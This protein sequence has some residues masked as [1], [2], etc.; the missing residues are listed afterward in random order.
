MSEAARLRGRFLLAIGLVLA[1]ACSK[2]ASSGAAARPGLAGD[3][4]KSG[5]QAGLPPEPSCTVCETR[6]P[7]GTAPGPMPAPFERCATTLEGGEGRFTA[8]FTAQ[9]REK[10]N[11]PSACCYFFSGRHPAGPG[12]PYIVDGAARVA[13][14]RPRGDW[15]QP[16]WPQLPPGAEERRALAAKWTRAGLVEHASIAS[17]ARFAL[18]L[19]GHGAPADLV[20]DA[21]QA[22]MDEVKHARVSFALASAYGGEPVGPGP[23]A[24]LDAPPRAK[25]ADVAMATL[26]E[27]GLGETVAALEA[28]MEATRTGDP[29]VRTL[30]LEIADDEERH[31]ELAWRTLAWAV[32]EAGPD[33]GAALMDA[34]LRLEYAAEEPGGD[35]TRARVLRDIVGPCVAAIARAA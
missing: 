19:L 33:L 16:L 13:E 7:N 28:R 5:S 20:H 10:E 35:P 25:L 24:T 9:T 30:L 34:A 12:R 31:A 17:F 26:I 3:G 32:R 18:E 1:P 8:S 2:E 14:A 6:C 4:T 11:R 15:T 21:H 29:L 27:G 23:L 22:A